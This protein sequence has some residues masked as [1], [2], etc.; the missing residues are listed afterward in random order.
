MRETPEQTGRQNYGE[1]IVRRPALAATGRSW[2]LVFPRSGCEAGTG[3][4]PINKFC[5]KTYKSSERHSGL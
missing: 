4:R 3:N 5:V 1:R 2:L